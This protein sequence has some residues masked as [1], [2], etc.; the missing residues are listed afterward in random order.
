M[1]PSE[2]ID[3]AK[4]KLGLTSDYAISIELGVDR[5]R[6]SRY[7]NGESYFDEY[8]TFKV[9]EIL[10]MNPE[11]IICDMKIQ[12]EKNEDKREFWIEQLGKQTGMATP[13]FLS[14][15]STVSITV[16]CILC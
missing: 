10:E 12:S 7:R 5:K 3:K 16:F 11:K 2:Y 15:L 9:A 8:M 4:E 14:G 6:I 1:K 13:L